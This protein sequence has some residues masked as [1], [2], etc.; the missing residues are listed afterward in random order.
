MASYTGTEVLD[1]NVVSNTDTVPARFIK[2]ISKYFKLAQALNCWVDN[3]EEAGTLAQHS[4][5]KLR[6]L[7]WFFLY[8]VFSC[9]K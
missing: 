9:L 6:L 7:I 5:G 2:D 3:W 4:L 1:T 8:D